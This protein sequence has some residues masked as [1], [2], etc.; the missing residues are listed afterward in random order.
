MESDNS[1]EDQDLDSDPVMATADYIPQTGEV[2]D[3]DNFRIL[4]ASDIHLGFCDN[5]PARGNNSS[6]KKML[7]LFCWLMWLVYCI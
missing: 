6:L 4:V 5:N 2:R 1:L 7:L 3:D